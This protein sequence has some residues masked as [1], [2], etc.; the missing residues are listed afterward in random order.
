MPWREDSALVATEGSALS[1]S[2]SQSSY[3]QELGSVVE[4]C[5]GLNRA[6]EV[7]SLRRSVDKSHAFL[8]TFFHYHVVS[9]DF[10]CRRC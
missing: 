10:C 3:R 8:L 2:L 4:L 7:V 1:L 9:K 6:P 5:E